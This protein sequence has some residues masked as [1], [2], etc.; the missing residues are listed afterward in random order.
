MSQTT[1]TQDVANANDDFTFLRERQVLEIFP[2]SKTQLWA[3]VKRGEFP[4]PCKLS[5]RCTVWNR[6]A[7]KEHAR[8]LSTGTSGGGAR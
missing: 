8:K 1:I 4:A 6:L 2:I 5:A 7:L 3:L